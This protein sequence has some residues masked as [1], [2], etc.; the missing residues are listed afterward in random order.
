MKQIEHG[1]TLLELLIVVAI[2][3]ILAAVALPAY[4]NY[5]ARAK[6]SEALLASS[7]CRTTVA[8]AVQAGSALPTAGHW[9]CETASTATAASRFVKSIMTNDT[10]AVRV[11]L[12]NVSALVNNQAIV[13]RPWADVSRS[14]AV[15]AGGG[16][17]MWDCGP[18][19]NNGI[20]ISVYVPSSCRASSTQIGS[21][22]GFV[23]GS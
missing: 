13:L 14:A 9:G 20:D 12:Q 6:V 21:V 19:P 22:S 15:S 2:I 18:D 3:G 10:G 5:A 23:S 7:I 1:F 8:E 4:Q 17:A 11:E 16:V